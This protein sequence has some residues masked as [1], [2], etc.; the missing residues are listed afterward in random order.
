MAT[1]S[2]TTVYTVTV[3]NTNGCFDS[4]TMVYTI[5]PPPIADAGPDQLACGGVG[6]SIGAAATGGTGPY[7]YSWSPTTGLSD[8][9]FAQPLASPS[10]TTT[11]TLTVTDANGCVGT[12]AVTVTVRPAPTASAG[13]DRETCLGGAVAL[14][15]SASGGTGPYTYSWSPSAGLSDATLAQPQASPLAT[16]TYTLT[17]TDAQGCTAN[18]DAV[19]TVHDLPLATAGQ[20]EETCFGGSVTLDGSASGGTAPYAYAWNPVTG[21]SDATLAQPTATPAAST[22]YS[23]VVTD[24]HGCSAS[25][26]VLVTVHPLPMV[27]AG[28]DLGLCLGASGTLSGSASGGTAPYAYAW[29]PSGG[30]NDATLVQPQVT[31]TTT[32][33]YTLT[34][35][36]GE[37]CGASDDVVVTVHPLPV[38]DAG[39]DRATNAGVPV[40]IGQV[41]T[42]G[43]G[44]YGYSWS[45]STALSDPA[46]MQPLAA[47]VITTV[48]TVTVTD[49]QGCTDTD[50]MTVTVNPVPVARAGAD[51]I[52]CQGSGSSIGLPALGGTPPYTYSWSPVSGLSDPGIA[53][54]LA[55]PVTSTTYEVTVTDANLLVARDTVRVDVERYA[56]MFD[57]VEN[58]G[59]TYAV[60]VKMN[61][62]AM[63]RNGGANLSFNYD[64]LT[65]GMPVL[66]LAH[67]FSG[68]EYSPMSLSTP[69]AGVASVNIDYGGLAGQGT[70]VAVA[71]AWTDVATIRFTV[72]DPIR[73]TGLSWRPG[74]A[75][76]SPTVVFDDGYALLPSGTLTGLNTPIHLP[77]VAQ[78]GSDGGICPGNSMSIGGAAI[79]TAPPYSYSWTPSTGL[80]DPS[81]MQPSAAPTATST[82]TVTVM[83][84]MGCTGTDD[85]TVTVH[86]SP[87]ADAG[88]DVAISPGGQALI[89]APASGGQPPYGYAWSPVSGL[90]DAGVMQPS[91]GPAATTTYTCVVTDAHG[92]T[93]SDVVRVKV[94]EYR[95]DVMDVENCGA[96]YAVKVRVQGSDGFGNGGATLSFDYNASALQN[97]VLEQ[98]HAFSGGQYGAMTIGTP[99]PGIFTLS[100]D[101]LGSSGGGSPVAGFPQ[102]TDVA[103]IRFSVIQPGGVSGLAVRGPGAAVSP[104]AMYDDDFSLLPAGAVTVPGT[105]INTV[106]TVNAGPDQ[107]ICPGGSLSIGAPAQG[108]TAPL[109]Y[110]WSPST[111]L[112]DASVAQPMASPTQSTT[113]TVSVTDARG[114]QVSDDIMLGVFT[115][116]VATAG[117]DRTIHV[118]DTV[119]IGGFHSGGM[120]PYTYL[121]SPSAGLIAVDVA[122]PLAAPATTTTYMV[123]LTDAHGCSS[124]D[125]VT[126][127]VHPQPLRAK[128]RVM[129]HGPYNVAQGVMAASL[130]AAGHLA[131]WATGHPYGGPP[132]QYTGTEQVDASFF[133][134]HQTVVDWVL[135][136]LRSGLTASSQVARRAGFLL[137]DGSIV[138]VD[139]SSPLSFELIPDGSYYIVVRHRNHLAVISAS[140]VAMTSVA[141]TSGYQF[142]FSSGAS[143]AYGLN[144]QRLLAPGVYGMLSGDATSDG[145]INIVDKNSYWRVQNGTMYEYL[146]KKADFN[147]DGNINIM[148]RNSYWRVNNGSTTQVP[149]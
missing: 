89:G 49:A 12:D 138:D 67:A 16:S 36:D 86:P 101:Y 135:V 147:L 122:Q 66:E 129:L 11:Y 131:T 21:L 63:F 90:N 133:A 1:P 39:A 77:P 19:V 45:P 75:V 73:S 79:G 144:P 123:T 4:D 102:W 15:G 134:S 34:V 111:G 30:L 74:F 18:D 13:Q 130:N 22:T 125:N 106:M 126:L 107:S 84:A 33:T 115:A 140:S 58:C 37:G 94:R 95:V 97:P 104:S 114:C 83:D 87:V 9:T 137:Q 109:Q 31:P 92:C 136:E 27:A 98:A 72:V 61:T 38:A 64:P 14:I 25:D 51:L 128:V 46:I 40:S 112:T 110:S 10:A 28:S 52:L 96:T 5:H 42:G 88:S 23:L 145:N 148:D 47:P 2:A 82:Y 20:D 48:Y 132:W 76:Q 24:A 119:Q 55:N 54:P 57:E 117:M 6:V 35:T 127:T 26:A 32:T 113:Y 99:A 78:A 41:A 65:L 53:Q 118:G 80:S 29:S 7:S 108:G 100:I 70:P 124:T 120:L 85:V 121:W 141:P 116:P 56:L 59:A 139:G 103:T 71:P 149:Q 62:C 8:A 91:A 143:Q 60:K 69:M 105:P 146:L 81:V 68:G 17:V 43:T 93:S 142:D 3:T 50:D 44:A